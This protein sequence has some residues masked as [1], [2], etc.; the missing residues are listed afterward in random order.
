[1]FTQIN[2]FCGSQA[3]IKETAGP[4][5][6]HMLLDQTAAKCFCTTSPTMCDED[7]AEAVSCVCCSARNGLRVSARNSNAVIAKAV[8]QRRAPVVSC[9][10]CH[11][12]V[13]LPLHF[14]NEKKK[15]SRNWSKKPSSGWKPFISPAAVQISSEIA[16][17]IVSR[18]LA[19]RDSTSFP[20]GWY[21][22][23]RGNNRDFA[24]P[25]KSYYWL[26]H[27]M[28]DVKVFKAA[29]SNVFSSWTQTRLFQ[30]TS[31]EFCPWTELSDCMILISMSSF[32]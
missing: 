14:P 10:L 30:K 6:D 18:S 1:M 31:L 19:E 26:S 8:Q 7:K 2:P 4:D 20:F 5:I 22:V 28:P 3:A 11:I 17:N 32:C 29:A 23:Q 16:F 13:L 9:L 27:F 24:H 12:V 15:K 25:P 21:V